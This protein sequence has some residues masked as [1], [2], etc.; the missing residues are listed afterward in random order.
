M[1]RDNS[2]FS[3]FLW[4]IFKATIEILL[5]RRLENNEIDQAKKLFKAGKTATEAAKIFQ[6][7]RPQKKP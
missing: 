3:Y 2:A 7:R 6:P 1:L 4:L 5:G